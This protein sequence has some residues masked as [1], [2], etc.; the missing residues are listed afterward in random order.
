MACQVKS[1][2]D[3]LGQGAAIA[4][5][6]AAWR[7]ERLPHGLI[8]AGPTGVGKTTTAEVVGRLF[9]CEKP[10]DAEP[11]DACPSCRLFPAGT[12]PDYHR[13]YRQLVRKYKPSS[14]AR[15]LAIEVIRGEVLEPASL[16]PSLGRGKVFVIE[17]A[18][19][20]NR[21]AANAL[22]KTLE[23]PQGRA[24]IILVTDQPLSLLST[25]R[26]RCQIIAFAPLASEL[27]QAQL[28]LAGLD[29]QAAADAAAL[30]EGSLGNALQWTRSGVIAKARE[31]RENLGAYVQGKLSF[32]DFR[33]WLE[34]SADDFAE[35]EMTVD[36]EGSRDQAKR[37]GLS[38]Y[39]LLAANMLRHRLRLLPDT[40][41]RLATCAAIDELVKAETF[42]DSNVST[43]VLLDSLL[44][45]LSRIGRV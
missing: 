22:L 37:R 33:K 44:A 21:E 10:A 15:D 2:K 28:Q 11:C 16:K 25:I 36:P 20:M 39:L 24:L 4:T 27:V 17:E 42:I 18:D 13:V 1:L 29:A 3:I 34:K 6:Q 9:L 35:H 30:A 8:F 14:V 41:R 12:H 31:L 5:I 38:L 45:G 26:S 32:M 40:Q 43:G 23:E 19:L 7:N